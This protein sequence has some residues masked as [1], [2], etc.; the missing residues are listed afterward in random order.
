[1]LITKCDFCG[2]EYGRDTHNRTMEQLAL[3]L[4]DKYSKRGYCICGADICSACLNKVFDTLQ[5][6]KKK[7][8]LDP[9]EVADAIKTVL[10]DQMQS[11][12]GGDK[13]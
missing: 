13:P 1:M 10:T 6:I 2:Y 8:V 11:H 3:P 7:S 4:E 9:E 5:A 12:K